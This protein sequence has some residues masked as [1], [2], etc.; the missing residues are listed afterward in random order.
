[1][2]TKMKRLVLSGLIAIPLLP[3]VAAADKY[4]N[5]TGNS[6]TDYARVTDVQPIYRT[7]EVNHPRRECWDEEVVR[8][9][10][11]S[12]ED[13]T[14]LGMI[15]GGALGGALGHNL[16][17]SDTA[18]LAGAVIGSAIGYDATRDSRHR[19]RDDYG[20]RDYEQRCHTVR[21][22]QTESRIDGYRVSYR[23]QGNH[24]TTRMNRDPGNRVKVRVR[25]TPVAH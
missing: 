8:R 15:V 9:P 12:H 1:M 21:E 2:N 3:L 20:R 10:I 24:Y 23:Y 11:S 19:P 7:V 4:V 18:K 17:H 14:A 5:H 6:F 25:V 22:Y 16:H 13:K